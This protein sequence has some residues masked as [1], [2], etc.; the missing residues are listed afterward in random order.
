MKVIVG[1]GNPGLQYAKTRHNAGFM[2]ADRLA[3]TFAKGEPV[4]GRFNAATMEANIAGERCLLVKPTTFMNRSGQSVGEVVNFFKLEPAKDIIVVTDDIALPVGTIRIK[5]GGG[6]GGHNGLL[7]VQRALGTDLFPRLRI[8][9]GAKPPMMAQHDWVLS[10]LMEE[11]SIPFESSLEK[12]GKA[13]EV[14]ITKGLDAAMNAFN[15]PPPD[16]NR[17]KREKPPSVNPQQ[18]PQDGQRNP[19]TKNQN[20]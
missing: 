9:V 13:C 11:E 3:D 15:A 19:E 10:R 18:E 6:A 7:D 17:P 2:V 8:G 20:S 1:L 5:P 16:P 12:A 14:F 4:K